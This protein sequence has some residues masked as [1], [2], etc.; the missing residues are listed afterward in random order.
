[1]TSSYKYSHIILSNAKWRGVLQYV[2]YFLV[3]WR[4]IAS[5]RFDWLTR[6][7]WS[8]P[9][10]D[11]TLTVILNLHFANK[12]AVIWAAE[13]HKQYTQPRTSTRIWTEVSKL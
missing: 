4:T 2:L 13:T 9:N 11:T 3:L 8:F 7:F 1:M 6:V 5:K 12:N 10:H